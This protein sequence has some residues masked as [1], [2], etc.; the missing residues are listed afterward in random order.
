MN[1]W[2]KTL[3]DRQI[4]S[5]WPYLVISTKY[6]HFDNIERSDIVFDRKFIFSGYENRGM[7]K[8]IK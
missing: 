3:P 2:S 8:R 1:I 4:L 6:G 5:K 7:G